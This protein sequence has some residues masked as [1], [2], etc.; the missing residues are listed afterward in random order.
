[1]GRG[2]D[3]EVMAES[4]RLKNAEVPCGQAVG[5][6]WDKMARIGTEWGLS[7]LGW[8]RLARVGGTRRNALKALPQAPH[9]R[10]VTKKWRGFGKA[11]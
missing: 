7:G 5:N 11:C 4:G 8:G 1:M 6:M 9:L 2:E 10:G 3:G